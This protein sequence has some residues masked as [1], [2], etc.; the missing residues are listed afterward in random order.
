MK[1]GPNRHDDHGSEE[2]EKG[3]VAAT[4]GVK[5]DRGDFVAALEK[6]ITGLRVRFGT[7]DCASICGK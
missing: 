7:G 5:H 6:M 1:V 3:P 2:Q 4:N